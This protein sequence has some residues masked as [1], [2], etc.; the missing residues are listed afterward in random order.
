MRA[1]S[2]EETTLLGESKA[3]SIVLEQSSSLA[4]LDRP[5]LVT[6]ERG[7]GKELIGSRL[8]YLSDRWEQPFLKLNCAA[9][10]EQLLES[11]LFGHEA[12]AFTDARRQHQG[13]F[14]RADGGS[15]LLDEIGNASSRVQEQILRVIEYGQ[16]TRVGGT[17][18]Q[19]VDVRI[20]A[21]TNENLPALARTGSF[22]SDLLDR[23]AFDV[24]TLPPLR[25]R[26]DD[27]LL[28]AEHFAQ[29]MASE[30]GYPLFPGFSDRCIE[31]IAQHDWPGNVRE[32]KNAI[33]RSVYRHGEHS[34]PLEAI[35]LDP[36]QTQWSDINESQT[37]NDVTLAASRGRLRLEGFKEVVQRFEIDTLMTALKRRDFNQS[38]TARDLRLSY[39]QLRGYVRKY[40][41]LEAEQTH[42]ETRVVC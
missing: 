39:D 16:F 37:G 29:Q 13:L 18:T 10:S 24:I 26:G 34:S 8:H 7:T 5:V 19:H 9:L 25:V 41:L 6:G 32:L 1:Q 2:P 36:F 38:Q 17:G 12:G 20:I 30:L 3:F 31:Q 33:E 14:E 28:I 22:R 40:Q 11:E 21:S 27:A 35:C 23:L 4:R 42:S 15:L